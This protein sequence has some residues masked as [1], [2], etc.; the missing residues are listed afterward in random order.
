[1][2]DDTEWGPWIEHDGKEAPVERGT[3][4]EVVRANGVQHVIVFGEPYRCVVPKSFGETPT[5]FH[6]TGQQ[7]VYGEI[8]RY[9]LRRPRRTAFDRITKIV[10]D[11][12]LP[13][14]APEGPQREKVTG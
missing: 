6:W 7:P 10:A 5:W 13:I 4:I 8:V 11:P 2:T 14:T 1:M 3:V 12:A 9:R